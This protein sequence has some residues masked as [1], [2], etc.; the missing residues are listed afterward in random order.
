MPEEEMKETLIM[1][2]AVNEIMMQVASLMHYDEF[3]RIV[4]YTVDK[5]IQ[6]TT[7]YANALRENLKKMRLEK[8][9][10]KRLEF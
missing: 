3:D 1:M 6:D 2:K 5:I 9:V 4:D 7:F 10:E 8:F